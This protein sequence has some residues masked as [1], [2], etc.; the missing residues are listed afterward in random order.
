MF[1]LLSRGLFIS[2]LTIVGTVIII[3]LS[4]YYAYGQSLESNDDN[5]LFRSIPPDFEI[6]PE[7]SNLLP[8]SS[9]NP[10]PEFF[11]DL[12]FSEF[13]NFS[14]FELPSP[15]SP[16]T[17]TT[18]DSD[19]PESYFPDVND[20][21]T[22]SDIGFQVDLPKDW[23]GKEIKFLN[24]MVFAAPQE[25]N[26]ENL[27][28]PVTMMIISGIDQR[29][30]DLITDLTTQLPTFQEGEGGGESSLK[31]GKEQGLLQ[32]DAP[33]NLATPSYSITESCNQFQTLPVTI[34]GI[35]AEQ[36]T[37]DC[38]DEQGANIKAKSYAFATQNDS[39]ISMAFISK[40]TNEYNQYLPLFEESVKTIKISNPV[41]IAKSEIYKK[42]KELELQSNKALS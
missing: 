41:N 30:L 38:I 3:P 4:N 25:I 26:L 1:Y 13:S 16:L 37:A 10:P 31:E 29:Y 9:S 39:I 6:P 17:T 24:N 8:S 34:N 11:S 32:G 2:L 21:Y 36:L 27:E 23:K 33:M 42:Y 19:S 14:D 28:E 5:S 40:S 18:D 20:T 12:N 35:S 22:N 15:P 7:F